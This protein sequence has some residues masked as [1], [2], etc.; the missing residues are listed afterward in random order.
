MALGG[1]VTVP[2]LI[3]AGKKKREIDAALG[4]SAIYHHNIPLR[5]GSSLSVGADLLS[6]NILQHQTVGI[7]LSYAF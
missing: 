3:V 4:M 1:A 7:G 6:D 5:N 2:C